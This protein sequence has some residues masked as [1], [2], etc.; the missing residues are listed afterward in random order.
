MCLVCMC[1][2]TAMYVCT[3]LF[4]FQQIEDEL[5]D[6]VILKTQHVGHF[7]GNPR[8]HCV[9][10][11]LLHVHLLL[12]IRSK[13]HRLHQL[14]HLIAKPSILISASS[15]HMDK[16]QSSNNHGGNPC[17][18]HDLHV[19]IKHMTTIGPPTAPDYYFCFFAVFTNLKFAYSAAEINT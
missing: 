13:F 14:L 12:Q 8:L 9:Q 3:N 15:L 17:V 11:H 16:Y 2:C 6:H 4:I 7:A 10:V 19:Y 1:V 18:L 5:N